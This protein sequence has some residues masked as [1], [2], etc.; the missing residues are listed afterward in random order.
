MKKFFVI[1]VMF[2]FGF[3]S[4]PSTAASNLIGFQT[5]SKNIHC[6]GF[7]NVGGTSLR[8]DILQNNAKI[9]T[10]QDCPLDFG[11]A[12]NMTLKGKSVRLCYG[13]TVADAYPVLQYGTTWKW[14]GF[15]CSSST[16]GVRCTN[17][18]GHGWQ[19]NKSAQTLF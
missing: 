9:P 19:I 10:P 7:M 5:P 6:A 13:D 3:S 4:L 11:N 1:L 15:V 12:F 8:C 16:A 14:A 17:L 2:G 18:S